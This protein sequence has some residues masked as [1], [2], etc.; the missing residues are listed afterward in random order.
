V[1]VWLIFG[2][3]HV[4]CRTIILLR[5]LLFRMSDS[6]ELSVIIVCLGVYPTAAGTKSGR[7]FPSLESGIHP[8][9]QSKVKIPSLI[10]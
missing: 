6:G 1:P 5:M 10:S 7:E 2:G 8:A 3:L 4:R 9:R